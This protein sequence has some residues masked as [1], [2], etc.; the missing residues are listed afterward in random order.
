MKKLTFKEASQ[1]VAKLR[2]LLNTYSYEYHVQDNPSVDDAVYDG[3]FSE[4]KQIEAEFPE[5]ITGDSPTQ[6]VGGE[7]LS[8]FKKVA[9]SSRMLS[10]NDVFSREDV[11][12]WVKRM[13]K[14][15][16]GG[17]KHEFFADIKLDGLACALV[18]EDGMFTQAITRGNS[19]EGEDITQNVRTIKNVPLR[20]KVT[21]GYE[22]FLVG[23]TEIRGEIVMLKSEFEK[24]NA[25]RKATGEPEF[26]NPRNLAAGTMRQL[27]P[28]LV[29]ERPLSFYAYDVLRS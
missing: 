15:L 27:D 21:K 3:L 24:L 28:R 9:H 11:E 13:D 7:P 20:L 25:A 5:L 4:L 2:D 8:G 16:P 22:H 6:R 14:L 29:A 12:A 26:A 17:I 19:F 1:R 18:Y 10:L 23:K